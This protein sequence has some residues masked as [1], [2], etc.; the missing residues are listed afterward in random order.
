MFWG[1]REVFVAK[2]EIREEELVV[3]VVM[4]EEEEEEEEEESRLGGCKVQPR[5]M[6]T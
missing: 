1:S 4:D 3:V 6:N 2:G 5:E